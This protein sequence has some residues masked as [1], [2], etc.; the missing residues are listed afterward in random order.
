MLEEGQIIGSYR[1]LGHLGGGGFASVWKAEHIHL[2]S[3][4]ALKVLRDDLA[5]RKDIRMRFLDEGRIH[6]RLRHPGIVRATDTLVY[7]GIAGL[8]MDF[9]EGPSLERCIMDA[10]VGMPLV[11]VID[12]GIDLLEALQFAH[13]RGVVHRDVKPANVV[14]STD[15]IEER[16]SV[17][18]D[19]GIAQVRGEL[20][21]AGR[22]ETQ[23]GEKMGTPGYMSPEQLRS[24]VEVDQ[25]SDLF[26]LGVVLLEMATG[27]AP[28]H[29][30]TDV[31][32][33]AAVL[34]GEYSIPNKIRNE[35]PQLAAAIDRALC[36]QREDRWPDAQAMVDEL[37][38]GWE[39]P[40]LDED[41]SDSSADGEDDDLELKVA[42]TALAL[43]R[44]SSEDAE[45]ASQ[46]R[47]GG[48]LGILLL[49]LAAAVGDQASPEISVVP[50]F[51]YKKLTAARASFVPEDFGDVLIHR[52]STVFG[53][54]K[55][56][57]VITT[58]GICRKEIFEEPV[59]F[60]FAALETVSTSGVDTT[61][62]FFSGLCAH[63]GE[64]V[65][66]EESAGSFSAALRLVEVVKLLQGILKG[67]R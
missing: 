32:T 27:T 13:E 56:G 29:R 22:G 15:G 11:D 35:A 36:Q 33:M 62:V 52:D 53:G 25:R 45:E 61:R 20:R 28:F 16:E 54:A 48:A 10:P 5:V 30:D 58:K 1:V 44:G 67:V 60:P 9:R 12:I 21:T 7:E 17:L 18:L 41:E 66:F 37:L 65:E 19:F 40:T 55:E 51:D 8:V 50:D 26:S 23:L 24:A 3:L 6:A 39:D 2:G 34:A 43:A 14:L 63:R 31:D 59:H 64:K 4:H 47:P 49:K 46:A 38:T 42:L 57:L